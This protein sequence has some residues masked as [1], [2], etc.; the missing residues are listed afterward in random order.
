MP[1]T[2]TKPIFL[3]FWLFI[4]VVWFM[5]SRS[6]LKGQPLR[7]RMLIGG[8]RSLLILVLGLALSD[9]R[10][11]E[12]SDRVNLLFVQDIS[13]SVPAEEQK[14]GLKLMQE[15]AASLKEEDQ[16][17]LIIFGQQPSLEIALNNDFQPVDYRSQVNTNFTNISEALQLAIGKLPFEGKN[18]IVLFSD[19]NQNMEDSIEMAYLARS[20]GI[21]IYPQPLATWFNK[22]EVFI[23]K[24]ETPPAVPLETPF[25]IRLLVTTAAESEGEL[26]LLRNKKLLVNQT[27]KLVPGKN[28]FHFT[29]SLQDQGLYLYKAIIN[30]SRDAV[31]QNN[32][33]LSFTQATRKSQILF[34]AGDERKSDSL[35]R[36]LR[37]QGLNLVTSEIEELPHSIHGLLDYSAIILD[38]V[39]G[40]NLSFTA[41][42]NLEKY[43]KDIGGGL[44]MIGGDRS[45]GAGGYLKTPVEKALPVFMDVPTTFEIPGF[46]LILV[47]DKSASMA[48]SIVRKSKLEGAKIAAFSAVEMLNPIDKVAVL[49][50]DSDREWVIPITQA[51]E[52]R[53]IARKLSSLKEGGGTDLYPALKEAFSVLK[54]VPAAKKHII[55]LSDG[56]TNEADFRSLVQSMRKARITISTVA[57]GSDADVKLMEDIASWGEGRSYFTKNADNIPRIFTGETKIAAKKVI[58]EKVM[59]PFTAMQDEMITGFGDNDWPNIYGFVITYPKP[60]ARILLKTDE[61]PL[62]AAWPYGLGRSV[63]FTSDLSTRWGKD[64]V[65]WDHYPKFVSQ[66]IKWAQRKETPRNYDAN[67]TREGGLGTFAVDV[68]DDQNRFVNNLHLNIKV[69]FPSKADKTIKLDQTAPGRYMGS[70][71]AEEIGEYYISL[72][73]EDSNEF[74]RSRVYGY[75]I[76]YTD[77]FVNRGVD[78]TLLKRLADITGGRVLGPEDKLGDLFTAASDTKKYG[79]LLWPYLALLA[80]IL[81]IAD[82]AARKFESLGRFE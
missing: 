40:R 56:L 15:A 5:I 73:S 66:M 37:R 33:G 34:L 3:L 11:L 21:E 7:S 81:L 23:E 22:S 4:P 20:L 60:E 39:S 82:V 49:A 46:C 44:V 47:I 63:A 65:R 42:E 18:R 52:R 51:K 69:L 10:V 13:E 24:L 57:V 35:M 29:D 12:R 50:F 32:E 31:H 67:I 43:V 28:V 6:S 30:A 38:N 68:T 55:V 71:N 79:A 19:G 75:G 9:P 77:E 70:F 74:T 27:V 62:L 26:I 36:A 8:L 59:Q 17:G 64:W 41:M 80:L 1:I 25:E 76:P 61:G 2:L 45:F 48:G 78:Y 54:K 72:F 14:A 16:A 58:V 53:K